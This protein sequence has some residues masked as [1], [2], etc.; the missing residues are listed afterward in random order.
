MVLR[1]E[2]KNG[3]KEEGCPFALVSPSRRERGGGGGKK[4]YK[5]RS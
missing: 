1:R 5:R 4:G 2:G 3:G